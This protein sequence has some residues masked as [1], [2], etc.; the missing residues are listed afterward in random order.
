MGV[1]GLRLSLERRSDVLDLRRITH[2]SP[3]ELDT[4]N[5]GPLLAAS[6]PSWRTVWVG[7]G[8]TRPF[9][10]DQRG[11]LPY[12]KISRVRPFVLAVANHFNGRKLPL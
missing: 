12:Y 2:Q 10:I 1:V 4:S 11:R 3:N 9:A 6:C 5:G 8:H 7:G